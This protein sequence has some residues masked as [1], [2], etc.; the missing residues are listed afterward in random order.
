M[1][2]SPLRRRRLAVLVASAMALSVAPLAAATS[3]AHPT[4]SS[5][6]ATRHS[7][8]G[9]VRILRDAYGV[10]QVYAKTT[11]GLFRGY[12]YAVAQDRL[13]QMEMSRRSTQ[14]T[15]SEVLGPDYLAFDK[16][17]RLGFDP[18]AI[19]AQVAALTQSDRDILD[20]YA[21]G[22]NDYLAVLR[23]H[24]STLM[25]KEFLDY[26]FE[27]ANWTAFDVAMVWVG[28]MANRYSDSTSEIPNY[29]LLQTLIASKGDQQGRALFD[30]LQWLEDTNAPTTVPRAGAGAAAKPSKVNLAPLATGVRD[31]GV[32]MMRRNGAD[33]SPN[34][35]PTASNIWIVG[36]QR[37]VGAK[38]ILFNGPQFSWF[39]PSYVYGIGLHGAG[40]DFA[41]TTPFAYPAV[42]FGTN[43][44][45]S[46]GATAG[47]LNLVDMYQEQLNPND[48]HE[49]RYRGAWHTMG[50]RTVTIKVKG[51]PD[52]SYDI[53][54][55]V[56]GAVTSVDPANARAYS[57]KR[58]WTGYE[59]QSL[60]AWT[61][62]PTVKDFRQF[63]ALAAKFAT[64]INWY[65]A[66]K[67]GNIGYIAPGRLPIRPANQDM[68]LP[69]RGDGTMEWQGIAPPTA[70]PTTYN[71][72]QG[73]IAN[74]NNQPAAGFNTDFGNWSVVD[75]MQEIDHAFDG[76]A[77]FTSAA[78]V[79]LNQRFAFVDLNLRYLAP[80]L[81]DAVCGLPA[82]D[83]TRKDVELI[84]GWS[85]ETRD[86]N[87]D[88]FY[89]GAQPA[90]MR[91][92][93]PILFAKVLGDD[94]P[95]AVAAQYSAAPY[96]TGVERRFSI[97][98]SAAMKLVYN[99]ILGPEAGVHQSVDLFNGV[100]PGKVL[101]ETYEEALATV[102]ATHGTNLATWKVPIA[103]HLFDS[104][105]FLGIP[106][107]TPGNAIAGPQYMNRGTANI[108]AVLG[109][110]APQLCLS[111]PPG[112]SGF[113]APDGTKSPNYR[114]QLDLWT[115]FQCRTEHLSAHDVLGNTQSVTVLH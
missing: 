37:S 96:A 9:D 85:G 79:A 32:E 81:K 1:R 69:A 66:D 60:I 65:Y 51:Q 57:K 92:W 14:G 53:R 71:P 99:A 26:G 76:K 39:N 43:S 16:D 95:P 75:R 52:V 97:R 31:V 67:K 34:S 11:Y 115:N 58:S 84:T 102:R 38:S 62:V 54:S 98:P 27:P 13:F 104:K 30:Q 3:A 15:V 40:W 105:N 90:I 70:N 24:K 44:D 21:A 55:T 23:A 103:T 61:K 42:I 12:G 89:D 47:A 80:T 2:R 91:A 20:G 114:D 77:P 56:H 25:P 6:A 36:K 45:I 113:I 74:W 35:H 46:W 5:P 68:R 73:F 100:D 63:Q 111:A 108:L 82:T 48:P 94:L 33:G 109:H 7:A 50:L 88:G 110:S 106:Q 112:Q 29:Q 22:M 64:T 19:E 83:H 107:T 4:T 101:L 59:V 86:R 8:R 87:G 41:G 18:G 28:T 72:K 78:I 49:Y 93:L 10:P 17:T